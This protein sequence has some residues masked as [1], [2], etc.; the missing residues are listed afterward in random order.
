MLLLAFVAVM[1]AN[2]VWHIGAS[3]VTWSVQ[4]GAISAVVL[5][6]VFVALFLRVR[7]SDEAVTA[8]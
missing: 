8:R 1:V 7:R 4:P 5:L 2:F 3:L 6:P